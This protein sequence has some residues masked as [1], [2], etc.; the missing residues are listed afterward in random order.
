MLGNSSHLA[1]A[2][3]KDLQ[4]ILPN[5]RKTQRRKLALLVATMLQAR[6][7]NTMELAAY[8]PLQTKR[9]DMRAQW[10]SRFLSNQLVDPKTIMQAIAKP[11]L[12][13]VTHEKGS[14]VLVM[15]QTH[16][17]AGEEL[18]V[19]GM[20]FGSRALPLLW[21]AK[22]VQG[23]IGFEEQKLLLDE[24]V[25][26]IPEKTKVVLLAD[27]FYGTADLIAYCQSKKWDYRLR[28]KNN[29][30]VHY[31][32]KE[33]LTGDLELLGLS[34]LKDVCIT[35]VHQQT[36]IGVIHEM[37]HKE[38]WIIAMNQSP[39]FYTTLDYSMRWSIEPM[40]SDFKSRG[41]GLTDTHLI[42]SE[43][44]ERLI[45]VMAIAMIWA[46]LSGL[47]DAKSHPLPY[48]KKQSKKHCAAS[49]LISSE[50]CGC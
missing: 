12:Q 25:K 45:L 20:R 38:P 6:T 44:L 30:K 11:L 23:N 50:V 27:R 35:G 9:I 13:Q 2:I 1:E 18:L 28:L 19:I 16:V 14:L 26:W 36:H 37:G 15:D 39:N 22:P 47:W 43:R 46:A 40:F 21:L 4:E 3:Y 32:L 24:V 17:Y 42:Y 5:Q 10:I 33:C 48:E 7:A 41:F 31:A 34:F 8:L 29:L 49:S